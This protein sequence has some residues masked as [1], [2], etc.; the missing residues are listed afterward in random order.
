MPSILDICP[1]TRVSESASR[2]RRPLTHITP[3]KLYIVTAGQ[4]EDKTRAH[5]MAGCPSIIKS[6]QQ[7]IRHAEGLILTNK[8]KEIS[9]LEVK[10]FRTWYTSTRF[11]LLSAVAFISFQSFW[12][13]LSINNGTNSNSITHLSI[14]ISVFFFILTFT[15]TP[16]QFPT[17]G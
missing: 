11:L 12:A 13:V 17:S 7:D 5:T 8:E 9:F 3:T 1:D 10:W 16:L 2:T 14:F 6:Q 15:F 4:N